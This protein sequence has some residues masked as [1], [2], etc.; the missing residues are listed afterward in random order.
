MT[1]IYKCGHLD[2]NNQIIK[3][4]VFFGPTTTALN[5]LFV[6]DPENSIFDGLFTPEEKH[7]IIEKNIPVE[8]IDDYIHLD[9]TIETIKKKIIRHTHINASFDELYL[10]AKKYEMLNSIATYQMLTQNEKLTLTKDRLVQFLLNID[11]INIADIEDKETYTYDDILLLGLETKQLLVNTPIGQNFVAINS[12]FPHTVNPFNV[13]VY[14]AFLQ[15]YAED[16]TT[17]TNTSILMNSVPIYNNM[18]YICTTESVLRNAMENNLSQES[19]I[20]IYFPYLFKKGIISEEL[21]DKNKQQLMVES[22]EMSQNKIFERNTSNVNL[23]YNLYY[24]RLSEIK[25][26]EIGIQEVKFIIHPN[27]SFNLPLDVVLNLFMRQV[28][29]PLLNIIL[30]NAKKKYIVSMRRE[31]LL[32]VRKSLI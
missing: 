4:C 18:I 20:K 11:E 9:D 14:D 7:T 10:F 8:F 25:Y 6:S 23:F 31:L 17:T 30:P 19:S 13:L 12:Q 21:L 16:L 22:E 24:K 15:Q 2:I 3:L 5:E 32:M 28:V 27:Y 29:Y 26:N 1:Y